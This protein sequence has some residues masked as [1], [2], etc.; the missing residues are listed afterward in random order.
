MKTVTMTLSNVDN[1]WSW[2]TGENDILVI[3]TEIMQMQ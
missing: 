1:T 2:R 3:V